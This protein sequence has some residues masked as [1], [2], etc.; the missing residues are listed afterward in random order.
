MENNYY[1]PAGPTQMTAPQ[2]QQNAPQSTQSNLFNDP[3]SFVPQNLRQFNPQGRY[4]STLG[5][6]VY[7]NPTKLFFTQE[8]RTYLTQNGISAQEFYN[9]FQ[10]KLG[11]NFVQ[12]MPKSGAVISGPEYRDPNSFIPGDMRRSH[13]EKNYNKFVYKDELGLD[14]EAYLT[15]EEMNFMYSQGLDVGTYINVYQKE[16]NYD[17]GQME[18]ENTAQMQGAPATQ[19]ADMSMQ[20]SYSQGGNN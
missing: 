6:D 10:S 8:E 4:F 3:D 5:V 20:M 12:G 2:P 16:F 11:G 13:P 19:E 1:N 14:K 17:R 15:N 9:K 18:L 7:G